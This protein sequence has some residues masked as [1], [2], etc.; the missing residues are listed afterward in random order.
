MARLKE[1]CC[2]GHLDIFAVLYN[3]NIRA[4][5]FLWNDLNYDFYVSNMSRLKESGCTGHLDIFEVLYNLI[6]IFIH[7]CARVFLWKDQ[8][9]HF[10]QT[11]K[12]TRGF[13]LHRT[14]GDF[15]SLCKKTLFSN[16]KKLPS[17]MFAWVFSCERTTI[18]ISWPLFCPTVSFFFVM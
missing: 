3:L 5:I 16:R 15:C 1:S 7:I 18:I 8:N 4:C 2:T 13:R 6:N 12:F 10:Y 11:R 9:Y 17:F 14:L